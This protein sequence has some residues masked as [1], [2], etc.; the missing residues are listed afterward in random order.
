MVALLIA[1]SIGGVAGFIAGI[2]NAQSRKVATAKDI[3]E[4][5]NK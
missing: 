5:I 1:F 3:I 4:K 2:K